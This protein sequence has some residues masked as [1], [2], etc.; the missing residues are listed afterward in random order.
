M[1]MGGR[2]A[3][4]GKVQGIRSGISWVQNFPLNKKKKITSINIHK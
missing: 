1:S 3:L 4:G 2:V